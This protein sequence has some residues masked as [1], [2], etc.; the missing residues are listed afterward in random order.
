VTLRSLAK[1]LLKFVLTLCA[2]AALVSIYWAWLIFRYD[3]PY[4]RIAQ[5][6][7]EARVI[8]LLGKPYQIT[9]PHDTL[10][11][12]WS[13]EDRFGVAGREIAKEYRYRV[14]VITGDEYII[15]FD[16]DGHAVLKNQLTSP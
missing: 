7:T 16:S 3:S 6:D 14:P 12:N 10:K 8:S 13:S 1:D 5:G 9:A 4:K 15:G 2:L 11:E